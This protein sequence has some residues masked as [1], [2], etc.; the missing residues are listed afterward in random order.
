MSEDTTPGIE[1]PLSSTAKVTLMCT[2]AGVIL[3]FYIYALS[4][5]LLVLLSLVAVEFLL[6]LAAARFG[7]VRLMSR[8]ISLPG[9]SAAGNL[10]PEFPARRRGAEFRVPLEPAEAPRLFEMVGKALPAGHGV[11]CPREITLE[12]NV[13]AW[14]RLEGYRRGAGTTILGIG[15]DLMAGVSEAEI[16]A[17]L[18]HEITHAKLVQRGL[19]RWLMGGVGRAARLSGSLAAYN[20][21]A[22]PGQTITL[23]GATLLFRG[24]DRLTKMAARLVV[25]YS[26]QDE[27]E[28]DRGAAELCGS[29]PIRSSLRK[30]EPLAKITARLSWPERVAQIESDTG[31]S[32]WLVTELAAAR[33]TDDTAA[34]FNKYSTHPSL[35]DR[36]A[37]LPPAGSEIADDSPPA[38]HLLAA[39][40]DVAAKLIAEIQRTAAEQERKDS[41]ALKKWNRSMRDSSHLQPV[42]VLGVV[43]ILAG[44]VYGVLA[45]LITGFSGG[46]VATVVALVV[47]GLILYRL[48]HYR[49]R[50]TLPVPSFAALKEGSR[51]K[52]PV[53]EA[54]AKEI[55]AELKAI[56]G[57]GRK[58]SLLAAESYAALARCDYVRAYIAA[59]LC[60]AAS[61]GSVE[62]KLGLAISAAAL[63]QGQEAGRAL[64]AARQRPGLNGG[65]R[66]WGAGWAL[67]LCGEWPRA[68]AFLEL[69]VKTRPAEPTF[70]LMLAWCQSRRGKLQSAILN[71]RRACTQQTPDKEAAKLLI[72]LLPGRRLFA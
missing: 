65:L 14:V 54:R 8:V 5:S 51:H 55:E 61:R 33:P 36:L 4:V 21:S 67:A 3:L 39:P 59:R 31:F 52:P 28:A 10:P 50:L 13:N 45:G 11:H 29:S 27:F 56:T 25:A 9:H 15:Y 49:D 35:R 41:N 53:G 47:A 17:V 72:D 24:A 69:A 68:E 37:A 64:T 22:S 1:K 19:K 44:L 23:A 20:Q 71:A 6:V 34:P 30:L 43:L 16:E 42:Q 60:L 38:I 48:A 57:P 62:G 7:F 63:G 26:R 66:P 70:L 18:A 12:M 40:D 46:L 58:A 2:A 32:H